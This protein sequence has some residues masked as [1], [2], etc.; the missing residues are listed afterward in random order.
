MATNKAMAVRDMSFT[1][2]S[3]KFVPERASGNIV[4]AQQL[5]R[6]LR[7]F[8]RGKVVNSEACGVVMGLVASDLRWSEGSVLAP[9]VLMG[10]PKL[11]VIGNHQTELYIHVAITQSHSSLCSRDQHYQ[12]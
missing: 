5:V 9:K 2:L 6:A 12:L 10:K 3:S 11:C 8:T 7:V 4:F 1:C